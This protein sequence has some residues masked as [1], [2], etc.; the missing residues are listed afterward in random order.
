MYTEI[1]GGFKVRQ[2]PDWPYQCCVKH[3][4]GLIH[5]VSSPLTPDIQCYAPP[6]DGR[7][8]PRGRIATRDV[9]RFTGTGVDWPLN[10]LLR[11]DIQS[12]RLL[13]TLSRTK[14]IPFGARAWSELWGNVGCQIFPLYF[15]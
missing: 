1:E 14:M 3:R 2:R 13:R 12:S 5:F 10:G 6:R 9:V 8:S 15:S 11:E 4:K 7:L